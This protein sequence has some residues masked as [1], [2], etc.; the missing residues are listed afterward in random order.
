MFTLRNLLIT[1][2]IILLLITAGCLDFYFR[3]DMSETIKVVSSF[4]LTLSMI[5][6][7]NLFVSTSNRHYAE[8][9]RN[10]SKKFLDESIALLE[11]IYET[12]TKSNLPDININNSLPDN[13]RYLWLTV[14]RMIL[15]YEKIKAQITDKYDKIIIQE[16]EEYC[17]FRLYNIFNQHQNLPSHYF[18]RGNESGENLEPHSILVIFDFMKWKEGIEDPISSVNALELFNQRAIPLDQFDA[19]RYV[20]KLINKAQNQKV[21]E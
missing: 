13:D 15:R 8:D 4:A 16:H 6:A 7:L 19:E 14:A 20:E 2:V 5:I 9:N 10:T 12:F 1:A 3:N 11:R 18:E 17:R 21:T